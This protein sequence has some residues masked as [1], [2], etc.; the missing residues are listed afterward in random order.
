MRH[1]PSPANCQVLPLKF[2][3]TGSVWHLARPSLLQKPLWKGQGLHT[4]T[5]CSKLTVAPVLLCAS[6]S[7]EQDPGVEKLVNQGGESSAWNF[8]HGHVA[9][10]SSVLQ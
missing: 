4:R 3:G 5:W 10:S 2:M 6:T 9:P 7:R 8:I 1:E